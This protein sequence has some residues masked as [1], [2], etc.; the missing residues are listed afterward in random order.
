MNIIVTLLETYCR[1][2]KI[3][4]KKYQLKI[5]SQKKLFYDSVYDDLYVCDLIWYIYSMLF[6]EGGGVKEEISLTRIR[7]TL[8]KKLSFQS[9]LIPR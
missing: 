1:P 9:V 2:W 6:K 7:F 3:Y 4:C 8:H 5:I